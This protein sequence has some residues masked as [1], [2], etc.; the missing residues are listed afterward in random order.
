[1][2]IMALLL[3]YGSI[4]SIIEAEHFGVWFNQ[5]VTM[6]GLLWVMVL[7]FVKKIEVQALRWLFVYTQWWI[8]SWKNTKMHQW[9][10]ITLGSI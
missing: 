5:R 10:P 7:D 4:P 8:K 3:L 2:L 6:S 1:M 9:W